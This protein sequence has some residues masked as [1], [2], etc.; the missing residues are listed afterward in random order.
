MKCLQSNVI[1]VS[2][3]VDDEPRV[4]ERRS[5]SISTR[6]GF[7]TQIRQGDPLVVTYDETTSSSIRISLPDYPDIEQDDQGLIDVTPLPKYEAIQAHIDF[8]DDSG[9]V[10]KTYLREFYVLD[11][12]G[13]SLLEVIG[14]QNL[15]SN[16]IQYNSPLLSFS[17]LDAPAEAEIKL[18]QGGRPIEW[19]G[20][21]E[22][23]E[24]EL[25][26]RDL[27]LLENGKQDLTA[28]ITLGE[29]IL[30]SK[31]VALHIDTESKAP[32]RLALSGS[33]VVSNDSTSSYYLEVEGMAR[34]SLALEA[35]LVD[36]KG[37]TFDASF[38]ESGRIWVDSTELDVG[39]YTLV[40]N[41][42]WQGALVDST[43]QLLHVEEASIPSPVVAVAGSVPPTPPV[44]T[45]VAWSF[46]PEGFSTIPSS[47]GDSAIDYKFD[48]PSLEVDLL[49]SLR[50]TASSD[51]D[52][53]Y[54]DLLHL[55][56]ALDVLKSLSL[57]LTF[58]EDLQNQT[59]YSEWKEKSQSLLNEFVA[60][61]R[62]VGGA[63][64]WT[65][66]KFADLV[67]TLQDNISPDVKSQ[68]IENELSLLQRRC[69]DLRRYSVYQQ[70]CAFM[71][72]E[73]LLMR[74]LRK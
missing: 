59:S 46:L 10:L 16:Q 12:L 72:I 2:I 64:I 33:N 74:L 45:V 7:A 8:L 37:D 14:E 36:E 17:L 61:R 66:P 53:T 69:L 62:Q 3:Q 41:A 21:Y 13:Q 35:F 67:L 18:L 57:S 39:K 1:D 60:A 70:S 58:S 32:V 20:A 38:S 40:L 6:F 68:I 48:I 27:S 42:F 25:F 29:K 49:S 15:I 23:V 44:G 19:F 9:S 30:E 47:G 56:Q 31:E 22:L 4:I 28:L 43:S 63:S 65:D 24:N 54:S 55:S 26:V 73:R 71:R 5:D 51:G 11:E 34:E 50:T 52:P